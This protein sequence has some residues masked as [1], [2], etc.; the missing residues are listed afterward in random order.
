[1]GVTIPSPLKEH[2]PQCS[3]C[4][5]ISIYNSEQKW[6]CMFHGILQ[7]PCSFIKPKVFPLHLDMCNGFVPER[8]L[9][10]S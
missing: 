10:P 7:F 6:V 3:I 9:F 4:R 8:D 2:R 5:E 1:M